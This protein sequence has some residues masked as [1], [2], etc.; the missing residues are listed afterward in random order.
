MAQFLLHYS[1]ETAFKFNPLD[2]E[3]IITLTYYFML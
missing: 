1:C 2:Q 3:P